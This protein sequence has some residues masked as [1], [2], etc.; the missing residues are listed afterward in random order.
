MNL[1][2]IYMDSPVGQLQLV[3]SADALV[4]VLWDCEKPNRVKLATLIE[5]PEHPILVTAKAQ[6]EQYFAGQRTCFDVPLDFAG[7]AFQKSVWQAL[8][9]IPYGETRTYRE[10][11]LEIGN[12]KAVRAVGA[13]NGRNPISIIAPCHRVIGTNGTLVGFAGGLERKEIL[14][15]IEQ[16]K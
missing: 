8:L 1:S 14:L 16:N 2:Y 13:A 5:D 3:A 7:T 4:A 15:N 10:I 11:A 12:P 9:N 6:L